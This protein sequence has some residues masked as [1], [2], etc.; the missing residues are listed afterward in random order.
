M[1]SQKRQAYLERN[2]KTHA[3]HRREVF[4]QIT[5]PLVVGILVLLAGVGAIVFFTIQPVT[6]VGR[7]ASVSLIWLILPSLIIALLFLAL[8]AGLIYLV[9]FMA[10]RIPHYTLIIQLYVQQAKDKIGQLLNLSTEPILR[11]N[12]LWAAIR[13]ATERRRKATHE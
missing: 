1:D 10:H 3:L 9:S 7:W 8:L 2:P 5:V 4:W 13:Y 6:D 12:S 11:I